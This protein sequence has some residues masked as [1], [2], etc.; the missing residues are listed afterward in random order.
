MSIKNISELKFA[1]TMPRQKFNDKLRSFLTGAFGEFMKRQVALKIQEPTRAGDWTVE[2]RTILSNV[3]FLMGDE[4]KVTCRDKVKVFQ[5]ACKEAESHLEVVQAKN[6]LQR[7]LPKKLMQIHKLQFDSR[8]EFMKMIQ[9]FL[10]E[11]YSSVENL[12]D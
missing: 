6:T 3:S 10:P 12:W 9:E 5:E 1:M 7:Y 8:V 4:V 11:L 2:T